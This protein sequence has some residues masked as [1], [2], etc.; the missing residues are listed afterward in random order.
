MPLGQK[1]NQPGNFLI[2]ERDANHSP[3]DLAQ[4]KW[5]SADGLN[6]WTSVKYAIDE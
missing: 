6:M 3:I 2:K 4:T 5:K 1:E